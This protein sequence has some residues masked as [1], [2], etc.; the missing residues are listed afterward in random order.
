MLFIM[1]AMGAVE[2]MDPKLDADMVTEEDRG[3][4]DKMKELTPLSLSPEQLLDFV[5]GLFATEATFHQGVLVNNLP[6]PPL[7]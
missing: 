7:P 6:F 4:E 1:Q 3:L 2:L 5:D